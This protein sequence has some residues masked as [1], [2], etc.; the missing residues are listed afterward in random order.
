MKAQGEDDGELGKMGGPTTTSPRAM[1]RSFP[2]PRLYPDT[3]AGSVSRENR[4]TRLRLGGRDRDDWK[5]LRSILSSV[6]WGGGWAGRGEYGEAVRGEGATAS[7]PTA[8]VRKRLRRAGSVVGLAYKSFCRSVSGAS[9][10]LL[11]TLSMASPRLMPPS[12]CPLARISSSSAWTWS[13]TRSYTSHSSSS[14]G[15]SSA[16]GE[17][18]G[19]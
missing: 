14:S 9:S 13:M 8:L 1:P 3:S 18:S 4:R 11:T 19:R 16:S 17:P 7:E 2:P 15:P 5:A 12:P 10:R 6:L